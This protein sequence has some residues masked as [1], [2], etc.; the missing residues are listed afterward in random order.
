MQELEV[1]RRK[2]AFCKQTMI[3]AVRDAA[4]LATQPLERVV[5]R[6]GTAH[7][8]DEDLCPRRRAEDARLATQATGRVRLELRGASPET[9]HGRCDPLRMRA[10]HLPE[11]VLTEP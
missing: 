7:E 9:Q 6:N 3:R 5:V 1:L 8:V 2:V 10:E 11:L 4:R